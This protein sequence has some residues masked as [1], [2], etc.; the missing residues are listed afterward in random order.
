[1][2]FL[3]TFGGSVVGLFLFWTLYLLNLW[4]DFI[5]KWEPYEYYDS[6]STTTSDPNMYD[7]APE[8]YGYDSYSDAKMEAAPYDDMAPGVPGSSGVRELLA[9]YDADFG[10]DYNGVVIRLTVRSLLY[11]TDLETISQATGLEELTLEQPG[12]VTDDGLRHLAGLS[13]LR[14]LS[15]RNADVTD[16]G[17]Y[18]L[19]GLSN[20]TSLDLA[21]TNVTYDGVTRLRSVLPGCYVNY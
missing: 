1:M 7:S 21:G 2:W 10:E 8:V 14:I 6:Y 4:L 9:G 11:N 12:Y 3:R 15:L 5:P 19:E 13:R 16:A 17:L 20:L 18:H